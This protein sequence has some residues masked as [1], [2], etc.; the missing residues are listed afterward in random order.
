MIAATLSFYRFVFLSARHFV[1][2]V[3]LCHAEHSLCHS[4]RSEESPQ[5]QYTIN[6]VSCRLRGDC[7]VGQALLA[8]T[9]I[10]TSYLA[11]YA[12]MLSVVKH[13]S[14]STTVKRHADHEIFRFAQDDMVADCHV[15]CPL[16][17]SRRCFALLSM[18]LLWIVILNAVK[19]LLAVYA[20]CLWVTFL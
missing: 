12:V 16:S 13:L 6:G 5:W 3:F 17:A 7:H 1:V 10:T 19:N 18:T 4:E 14:E 20:L 8:M 15:R 11:L 9:I 2:F